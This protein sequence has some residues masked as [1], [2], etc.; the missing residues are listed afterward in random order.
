[1]NNMKKLITKTAIN[2]A[3]DARALEVLGQDQYDS[4]K[5][6]VRS[7][8]ED[9]KAAV[10]W[11]LSQPL[12]VQSSDTGDVLISKE[13]QMQIIRGYDATHDDKETDGRLAIAAGLYALDDTYYSMEA[14]ELPWPWPTGGY[15][16]KR[17]KLDRVRQLT[18][19]GALIAAE[20][21]IEIRKATPVESDDITI[22]NGCG[23][24]LK[25]DE[26]AYHNDEI[27]D[28]YCAGCAE[29]IKSDP[30]SAAGIVDD[31]DE[32]EVPNG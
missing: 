4:N 11:A 22:C 17:G 6:A 31:L 5:D 30:E 28:D 27:G 25:D 16:D 7:I 18:I 12:R 20:I 13:R 29:A 3:A 1:M 24:S 26:I 10:N 23:K 15:P 19:S 21:D 32:S 14:S 8:K 2:L 9:F